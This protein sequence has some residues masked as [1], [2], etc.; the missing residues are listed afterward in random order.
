MALD[1]MKPTTTS[2]VVEGVKNQFFS[3]NA[4]GKI[5]Q[6][7]DLGLY[8]HDLGKS[9]KKPRVMS[10]LSQIVSQRPVPRFPVSAFLWIPVNTN[11]KRVLA[12]CSC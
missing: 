10:F 9:A 12:L 1:P 8:S 11:N 6:W 5:F 2:T 3:K 7:M 4:S